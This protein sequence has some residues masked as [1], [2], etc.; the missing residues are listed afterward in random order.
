MDFQGKGR[1]LSGNDLNEVCAT[2]RATSPQVW[3]VLSVETRGFGFLPD[4]RPQILFERHK[5]HELTSGRFSAA[6]PDISNPHAGGYAG[7][8]AE[9]PRLERAISLDRPA[10]LQSASWGL[11]QV[12]GFNHKRVGFATVDALVAAMVED[13][14]SQL[15]AVAHFITASR[16]DGAL[17]DRDWEAFARGYNGPDFEKNDYA[18]RLEAAHARLTLLLPQLRLRTGQAALSYLGLDPGSIDGL[19]GRR[20]TSA[21]NQFQEQRGLPVTGELDAATEAR[22]LAEAFPV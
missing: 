13:E 7:G 16:L 3:A 20:T 4:R 22:L 18:N 15:L 10:A 12:M 21:L 1:P 14:R 17:R 6:H 11:G 5:F 8:A 19:R 9:Y 2:L